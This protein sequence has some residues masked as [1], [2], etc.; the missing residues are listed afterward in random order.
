MMNIPFL[1]LKGQ[2]PKIRL[3]IEER[4]S[5]II[6]NTAFVSGTNVQEFEKTFSRLHGVKYALGLSSGTAGNHLAML[7]CEIVSGDEVIVPVNTFI[8][9]AEAISYC[10]ATPVFSDVDEK[11]F[12]IDPDK[13]EEKITPRTKA[14]NP[15][16]LFGQPADMASLRQITESFKL[17]LIEDA[18]QAHLAEYGNKR[19]GGLG[20]I[21]SWSFYPGKNLG[22][23][24][25]AGAVT[26]DDKEMYMKAKKLRD[27]GSAKRY[28]HELVGYNYRMSEFQA[29]VLNVKM[30]YI[31][32][33]TE[34]R[35][36]NAA[37]YRAHL[38]GIEEV[39]TPAE[40]DNAKHVYHLYVIRAQERDNLQT[41]LNGNG[42]G[43]G[44]H[45]PIPLHLTQAYSHLEHKKGEFP[46]AEK[47]ANE[48]LSLPMYPE[49]NEQQIEYVCK[50]IRDFYNKI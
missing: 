1:D 39:R 29:A 9:T 47:L 11:T 17:H 33:W 40:L 34:K 15:V 3:E 12:N 24:G 38:A 23:W 2:L 27:H 4:F 41:F 31:E 36:I 37:R 26:T 10:G 42:I 35:R 6:N 45:Y 32:D 30:K 25:E 14:I 22:A 48:I 46:V 16:H 5:K 49:L 20:R 13:I 28:H 43:T 18:A 7:C 21:A 44:L 19:A 8:A 50:N